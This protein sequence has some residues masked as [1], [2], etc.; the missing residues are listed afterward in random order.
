[1]AGLVAIGTART[2]YTTTSQCPSQPVVDGPR[3]RIEILPR[4]AAGLLGIEDLDEIVVLSWLE[5]AD[6][7]RLRVPPRGDRDRGERGVFALRSPDRPN[8]VGVSRVPLVGIDGRTLTV[9]G[10]DV[11]DGTTVVDLKHPM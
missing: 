10:L 8:P 7:E 11:L 5:D 4:H 3:C 9:R 2:P 6:R 1:M